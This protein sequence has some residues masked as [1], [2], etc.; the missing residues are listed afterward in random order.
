MD[1]DPGTA[2]AQSGYQGEAYYFCSASCKDKFDLN[3]QQ[4]VGKS[5]V[6]PTGGCCS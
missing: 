6:A 3:P 4:Y 1:V 2:A 5:S